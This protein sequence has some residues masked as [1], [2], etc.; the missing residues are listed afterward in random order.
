MYGNFI[1]FECGAPTTISHMS[2]EDTVSCSFSSSVGIPMSDGSED[3][4]ED[5]G[6]EM[7]IFCRQVTLVRIHTLNGGWWW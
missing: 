4:Q 2:P 5:G 7:I 1:R 3:E 6:D